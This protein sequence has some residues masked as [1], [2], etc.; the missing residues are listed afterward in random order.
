VL[1]RSGGVFDRRDFK[2]TGI[3]QD[4]NERSITVYEIWNKVDRR[5]YWVS[6]GYE[7]LCDVKDDP[8][9]LENFFPCPKP[10]FSTHTNDSLI[11]VPDFI[12]WQDQAMQ[13]DELTQRINLLSK[14]CKVA[15]TYD[16]SNGALKRLLDESSENI[17]IPVDQ[18]AVYA[19]KG[20]VEGSISFFPLKE[21]QEVL[22]TLQEVRAQCMQDLD[23]VL[24]RNKRDFR[25][26]RLSDFCIHTGHVILLKT[27]FF[28]FIYNWSVHRNRFRYNKF[29]VNNF[30]HRSR[31]LVK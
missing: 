22:R 13:V 30:G 12:E 1:F 23:V 9:E 27:F 7:Y 29:L 19:E 11:P 6:P 20:G 2:D 15:G 8:L 16:A 17:L 10:L 21:I 26:V 24:R 25:I 3:F 31:I 18:W 4:I 14:A 28:I 5:V